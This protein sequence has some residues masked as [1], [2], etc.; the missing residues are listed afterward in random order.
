MSSEELLSR[1][2]PEVQVSTADISH[3]ERWELVVSPLGSPRLDSKGKGDSWQHHF[4][5][6]SAG[7]TLCFPGRRAVFPMQTSRRAACF[8]LGVAGRT[9]RVLLGPTT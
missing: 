5:E 3:L 6:H 9:G 4:L 1:G 2:W 8:G 7:Q